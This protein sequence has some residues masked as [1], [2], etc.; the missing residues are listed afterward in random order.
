MDEPG[1]LGI[2]V[3]P[4]GAVWCSFQSPIWLIAP[5]AVRV[6]EWT[7]IGCTYD[8]ATQRIYVDGVR[9]AELPLTRVTSLTP[10]T[11]RIGANAPD[12]EHFDGQIDELRFFGSW[13]TDAEIAAAAA[14]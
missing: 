1:E 12:G 8:G 14:R 13:R 3:F 10:G 7:H 5:A 2:F 9:V 11:I 6:D 4:G